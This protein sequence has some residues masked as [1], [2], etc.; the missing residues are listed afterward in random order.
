LL[1]LLSVTSSSPDVTE[2]CFKVGSTFSKKKKKERKKKKD[3]KV[4]TSVNQ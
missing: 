3:L 2:Q 1:A 4:Q